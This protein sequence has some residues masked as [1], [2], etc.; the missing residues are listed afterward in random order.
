[1]SEL[2]PQTP[3]HLL[4][5]TARPEVMK[6]TH[7]HWMDMARNKGNITLTV[8][9][10]TPKQK[11][12][13]DGFEVIVVGDERKGPVWPTHCLA[14][15]LKGKP[16]DIVILVS[17][18]FYAPQNWDQWLRSV[19]KNYD[20]GIMV[21]DGYQQGGCV[22]IPIMT[23]GTLMKLNRVIYHPTYNWQFADAELYDNLMKMGR[24]KNMR[25]PK[26]PL[27]EHKH[28]ANAKRKFD[29]VDKPGTAIAGRDTQNYN[30]RMKMPLAERL[31]V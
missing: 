9:V 15:Q 23:F 31:K 25:K 8:A 26:L 17:D 18:D 16:K 29:A 21:N 1:M 5:P 28:W 27:F 11:Q 13:L 12:L 19:F 10:N 24:L 14:R 4:W 3:I 7:K 22:T 2:I 20:G 6:V 30:R